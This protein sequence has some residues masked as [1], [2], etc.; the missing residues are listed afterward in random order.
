MG[1]GETA[2]EGAEATR[3]GSH[4]GH[5]EPFPGTFIP[6][7]CFESGHCFWL[8][9][10][11]DTPTDIGPYTEFWVVTPE[12]D[13][14]LYA[15]PGESIDEILA[16]HDFDRTEAATISVDGPDAGTVHVECEGEDGTEARISLDL[17]RTMGTRLLTLA[18]VLT[19]DVVLESSFGTA[20]STAMLN[21]LVDAN[22]LRVASRTETGRRYRLDVDEVYAVSSGT[23]TLDS[24][25]LGHVAPPGRPIEF[26]GAKT[27]DE[28][29]VTPGTLFLERMD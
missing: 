7:V 21:L 13:R 14:V 27:V 8:L 22:G 29:I 23:A 4:Q 5:L 2:V 24:T 18:V 1:A 26:G 6:G 25:D 9:E 10:F 20:V 11:T 19:P 17:T 15:D 16:Y 3:E 12:G 28:P